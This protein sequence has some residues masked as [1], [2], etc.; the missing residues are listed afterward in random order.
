VF[1][2][3]FIKIKPTD[4]EKIA[5]QLGVLKRLIKGRLIQ[6]LNHW[7]LRHEPQCK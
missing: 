4:F 1:C 5:L 6:K 3:N 2:E 7:I